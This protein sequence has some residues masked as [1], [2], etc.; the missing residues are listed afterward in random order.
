MVMNKEMN[1]IAELNPNSAEGMGYEWYKDVI[2][3]REAP[4]E[5]MKDIFDLEN[6]GYV[7]GDSAAS[8]GSANN[9][10]GVYKKKTS[11]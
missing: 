2:F 3:D 6:R 1:F 9:F 8:N 7:F 11:D 5:A 4:P 10:V